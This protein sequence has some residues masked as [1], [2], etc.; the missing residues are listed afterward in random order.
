MGA[1]RH[2]ISSIGKT[3][4]SVIGD[5]QPMKSATKK[6]SSK[7]QPTPIRSCGCMEVHNRLLEEFPQFRF[8]QATLENSTRSMLMSGA[9]GRVGITTIPVV[10]H[11]VSKTAAENISD[12]QIKSQIAVLN[13][14]FRATNPDKIKTPTVWK[15]LVTDTRIQFVL[16]TKNPN[17]LPTTGIN[18]KTTTKASFGAD[19]SVKKVATGGVAAWPTNKYLNIWVCTLSG[20]LLGYAQFPGGPAVTDGVVILNRAFGTVGTAAAPFNLGRSATH[21]IGHYLNLRHIWGDTA[22]CSG[23]DFVADTPNALHPNFGTP[24]FPHISCSNGPNGDMFVNYMDYVDDKAMVMFSAGQVARMQAT[25]D[26]P[27]SALGV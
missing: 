25:L 12:A 19:D 15:G 27:R 7:K 18:R 5:H 13:K 14:D 17:G 4:V 16:A 22:D 3:G 23:T 26:G 20:S 2:Y 6:T 10:V 24:A 9:V 8:R 21:E 11:V 1:G